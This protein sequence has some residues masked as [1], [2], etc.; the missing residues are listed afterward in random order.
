MHAAE[1]AMPIRQPLAGVRAERGDDQAHQRD[2]RKRLNQRE[3]DDPPGSRRFRAFI[4]R[5]LERAGS[6][7]RDSAGCRLAPTMLDRFSWASSAFAHT[8]NEIGAERFAAEPPRRFSA[9]SCRST[10]GHSPPK[11]EVSFVIQR[12]R[13][14]TGSGALIVGDGGLRS[15]AE[16][17]GIPRSRMR[18]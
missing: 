9:Y 13:L 14:Q 5:E 2:G 6:S 7:C 16:Y 4:M 8:I 17:S 1:A 12:G 11:G 15:R 18:R 10:K 3:A